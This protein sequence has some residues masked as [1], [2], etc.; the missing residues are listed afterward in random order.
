MT[1]MFPY[2]ILPPQKSIISILKYFASV[3]QYLYY[4]IEIVYK[5]GYFTEIILC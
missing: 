4:S 3:K 2:K 5:R 1:L